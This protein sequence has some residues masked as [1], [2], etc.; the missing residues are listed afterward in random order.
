MAGDFHSCSKLGEHG[1]NLDEPSLARF[2][3]FLMAGENGLVLVAEQNGELLGSVAGLL[4]PWWAD[5][6]QLTVTEQWWWV[7]RKARGGNVHR[8]LLRALEAWAVSRGAAF[9]FMIALQ[10][11]REK[12]LARLYSRFGYAPLETHYAKRFDA[13]GAAIDNEQLQAKES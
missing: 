2:M 10:N 5:H 3:R 1:L 13:G 9:V 7:S 11:G 12:A 8:D 4:A 6:R